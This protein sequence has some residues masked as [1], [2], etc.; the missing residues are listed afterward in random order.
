[1]D[2]DKL[3][4]LVF[5]FGNLRKK[6]GCVIISWKRCKYWSHNNVGLEEKGF[7]ANIIY[8]QNSDSS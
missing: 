3:A 6:S 2:E 1:M 4:H 7:S 5:L 8:N